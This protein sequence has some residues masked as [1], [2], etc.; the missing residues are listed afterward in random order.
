MSA[1][2]I[3]IVIIERIY[4]VMLIYVIFRKQ[5]IVVIVAVRYLNTQYIKKQKVN[6]ADISYGGF[7]VELV[8]QMYEIGEVRICCFYTLL[9]ITCVGVLMANLVFL[10]IML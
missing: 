10:I 8:E 6:E 5:K 9:T 2:V 1:S 7:N 4:D 3:C